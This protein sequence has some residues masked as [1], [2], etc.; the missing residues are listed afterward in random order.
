MI[1]IVLKEIIIQERSASGS[2]IPE[3]AEFYGLPV[4]D[5]YNFINKQPLCELYEKMFGEPHDLNQRNI[6]IK[7]QIDH[8]NSHRN[9]STVQ[10]K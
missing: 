5:I 6:W 7:Q 2:A 9:Y 8:Y 10:E 1:P 4:K 3:L